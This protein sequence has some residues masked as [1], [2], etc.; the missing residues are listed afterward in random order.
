[1][2]EDHQHTS[3]K[4]SDL[5]EKLA[6]VLLDL[7]NLQNSKPSPNLKTLD[8]KIATLEDRASEL[9][10]ERISKTRYDFTVKMSE[11]LDKFNSEID[12]KNFTIQKYLQVSQNATSTQNALYEKV[13]LKRSAPIS[14]LLY[15]KD[16][17][18]I[19]NIFLAV[20]VNFGIAELARDILDSNDVL[21]GNLFTTNFS[22]PEMAI[23]LCIIMFFWSFTSVI[24]VQQ[25][26]RPFFLLLFFHVLSIFLMGLFVVAKFISYQLPIANSF[27]VLC[28]MVRYSMKMHSYFREKLLYGNGKNKYANIIPGSAT[29]LKPNDIV[30]PKIN[31]K[32]FGQEVQRFTYYLFAPT[33]IY[34]DSYPKID[35][36]IRWKNLSVHMFDFFGAIVYT[37][38]IF[39]AFCV[40]EFRSASKNITN[41]QAVLLSWFRSMLPGTMV[42][43]LIFFAV[44]HSW[45][46]IFAEILNFADRKFYDDWWNAKD[47]GTFYRKI[48]VI[49][50]EWLHTYVF[51]DIQRFTNNKIGP[52]CARIIVF[53]FSG[54][55]T[56]VIIDF[57]LGFFFPYI[58]F[59][60][61]IPGAFMI[62]FNNRVSRFYN[63]LVWAFLIVMMGLII[64]LYSLEYYY[65]LDQ[66]DKRDFQTYGIFAYFMPQWVAQLTIIY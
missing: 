10:Q 41:S 51:M 31:I 18:T 7:E 61:A 40:P 46:S 60:V 26:H 55:L 33:L 49:V 57:S 6:K 66:P 8:D 1:M 17:R 23:T 65:R 12:T 25:A 15:S 58:F 11:I 13:H 30:L 53:L 16:F 34:R 28:E 22:K 35:R 64:M 14:K 24:I 62:S 21:S 36:S 5:K 44:M 50:Y 3:D 52:S 19:Y 2:A 27:V 59:V 37:A 38:V 43:L 56:E 48:S 42:F 39:K 29:G 45:F 47:F 20:L 4:V 32:P 9:A 54:I 63:V